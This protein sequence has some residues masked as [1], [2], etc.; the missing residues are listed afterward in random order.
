MMSEDVEF[1]EMISE[2]R[3]LEAVIYMWKQFATT[4]CPEEYPDSIFLVDP[5]EKSI[6]EQ[7]MML[8]LRKIANESKVGKMKKM[9]SISQLLPQ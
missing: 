7:I 2:G 4:M 5:H 9:P 6:T 8:E 3:A 1:L